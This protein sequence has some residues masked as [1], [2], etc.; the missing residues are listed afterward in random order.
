MLSARLGARLSSRELVFSHEQLSE[1]LSR[2]G[3]EATP[4]APPSMPQ[5]AAA[6]TSTARPN[7]CGR[8]ED[9]H[10]KQ[11]VSC[12]ADQS[13]P[14]S[15]TQRSS[16]LLKVWEHGGEAKPERPADQ[17]D[18]E[19][20]AAEDPVGVSPNFC[21]AAHP[22]AERAA[23]SPLEGAGDDLDTDLKAI[24]DLDDLLNALEYSNVQ[25]SL[26]QGHRMASTTSR[27]KHRACSARSPYKAQG[28]NCSGIRTT[29]SR[30][31]RQLRKTSSSQQDNSN[32]GVCPAFDRKQG[33]AV[34]TRFSTVLEFEGASSQGQSGVVRQDDNS[35]QQQLPWS[36]ACSS[37]DQTAVVKAHSRHVAF[38]LPAGH[39]EQ[40]DAGQQPSQ[41]QS[42]KTQK[43]KGLLASSELGNKS[44]ADLIGIWHA[45]GSLSQDAQPSKEHSAC[46]VTHGETSKQT[47]D[48]SSSC[49]T[50]WDAEKLS[51]TQGWAAGGSSCRSVTIQEA[52]SCSTSQRNEVRLLLDFFHVLTSIYRG[53]NQFRRTRVSVLCKLTTNSR[54]CFSCRTVM[55]TLQILQLRWE[56]TPQ[57]G[58]LSQRSSRAPCRS[59]GLSWQHRLWPAAARQVQ[60]SA[61]ALARALPL[62]PW[63]GCCARARRWSRCAAARA[64]RRPCRRRRRRSRARWSTATWRGAWPTPSGASPLCTAALA[65]SSARPLRR[66]SSKV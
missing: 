56:E 13:S 6:R 63:A 52:Q 2:P 8:T 33:L 10:S 32:F 21:A 26:P 42:S 49:D 34:K 61:G 65:T 37:S 58:S 43:G 22:P 24:M 39:T 19:H 45:S 50:F 53:S 31:G 28:R 47:E 60:P 20:I 44:A 46:E 66:R 14:Q 12:P 35:K 55:E 30:A 5:S 25:P 62:H 15:S 16:S 7:A 36:P 27:Q 59:W 4:P 3:R 51:V 38:T 54:V 18:A 29:A 40:M 9:V 64:A 17:A 48:S 41:N 11:R 57:Q 1:A 23:M